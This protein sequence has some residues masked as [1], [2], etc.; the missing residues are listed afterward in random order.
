MMV[1]PVPVRRIHLIDG[2]LLDDLEEVRETIYRTQRPGISPQYVYTHD[3]E[4]GD[5]VLFNN[6]GVM[7][8]IV[9]AFAEGEVRLFKQCNVAASEP[10]KGYGENNL[11]G[12]IDLEHSFDGELIKERKTFFYQYFF[13]YLKVIKTKNTLNRS[14]ANPA[15][16]KI[17]NYAIG[18]S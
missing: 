17:V 18:P 15:V 16:K 2:T 6:H 3:W 14:R 4:E 11:V 8:S 12:N 7:H 1:Y 13:G 9:G 5:L 10:P